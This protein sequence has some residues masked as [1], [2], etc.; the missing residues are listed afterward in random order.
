VNLFQLPHLVHLLEGL[1]TMT[2][3]D[4]LSLV[5]KHPDTATAL[6]GGLSAAAQKDPAFLPDLIAAVE[7]KSYT[8]FAVKH[9]GLLLGLAGI[10]QGDAPL[11][12]QLGAL[13]TPPP[14]APKP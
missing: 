7:T 13:I 14:P 1:H 4:V 10:I 5:K 2:T 3:P 11:V 8:G 6:L 12:A 9:I